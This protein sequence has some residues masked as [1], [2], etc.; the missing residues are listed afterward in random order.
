MRRAKEQQGTDDIVTIIRTAPEPDVRVRIAQ[1]LCRVPGGA[2]D[3]PRRGEI[4]RCADAAPGSEDAVSRVAGLRSCQRAGTHPRGEPADVARAQS[5]THGRGLERR[6]LR[7]EGFRAA[8]AR[9]AATATDPQGAAREPRAE[10]ASRCA[11][12][13]SHVSGAQGRHV[14]ADCVG[15]RHERNCIDAAQ[16]SAQ[17][18]PGPRRAGPAVAGLGRQPDFRRAHCRIH[19]RAHGWPRCRAPRR[20]GRLAPRRSTP[21]EG[22][23]PARS[24]SPI[25]RGLGR[26]ARRETRPA[27]AR[28][29]SHRRRS[30]SPRRRPKRS[31]PHWWPARRNR[32]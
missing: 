7:T 27:T 18:Q 5:R 6:S 1:L 31:G 26:A 11:E 8:A 20:C 24:R 14:V 17:R 9:G 32:R 28:P 4:L 3:R 22:L 29:R 23:R 13:R 25:C 30:R 15:Q 16:R 21:K 12:S 2:R 10:R 19:S